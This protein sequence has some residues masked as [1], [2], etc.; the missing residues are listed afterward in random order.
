MTKSIHSCK[1]LSQPTT[2]A[3]KMTDDM[4]YAFVIDRAGPAGLAAAVRLRQ[5]SLRRQKDINVCVLEKGSEV[6]AHIL[7]G[8]VIEPRALNEL[9][10][11]WKRRARRSTRLP[12]RIVFCFSPEPARLRLPTPPQMNNH[13][14]YIASLGNLVRWLGKAEGA[15]TDFSP[16]SPPPMSLSKT[17]L[18]KEKERSKPA[19]SAGKTARKNPGYQAPMPIYGKYT[20]FAEGCRDSLSERLMKNSACAKASM[21]T[22]NLRHR[23]QGIVGSAGEKSISRVWS[24]TPS[25][26]RWMPEPMAV[27]SCIIWKIIRSR[28]GL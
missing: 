4:R 19:S 23:H 5:L 28:S 27:R 15:I 9:I 6:G 14:N 16:D 12:R 21:R 13:G 7:S 17:A 11:D 22:G 2:Q 10:P 26:G 8:A 18:V 3:T 20:L 24:N 1:C 25:V